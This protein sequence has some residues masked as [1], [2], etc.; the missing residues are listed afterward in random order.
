SRRIVRQRIA[1]Q[2]RGNPGVDG[3]SQDISRDVAGD[4]ILDL[5]NIDAVT[6]V[7]SRNGHHLGGAEHLPESLVLGEVEGAVASVV[8]VWDIDRSAV[9]KSKL[10]AIERRDA[11]GVSRGGMVEVVARVEC[12]V[13][14]ELKKRTVKTAGAGARD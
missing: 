13:A 3:D 8:D 4:R 12:G 14:H 6:L 2:D 1:S 5:H 11:S 9:C 10:V 7:D